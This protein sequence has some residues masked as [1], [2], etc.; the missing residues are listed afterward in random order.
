MRPKELSSDSAT[1]VDVILHTIDWL[2]KQN[3]FYNLVVLLEPTSPLRES[4]DIDR[5]LEIMQENNVRSIVSVSKVESAHPLFLFRLNE[6]SKLDP[7]SGKNP[8]SVRRQDIENLYF[9]EG[10]VYCSEIELLR[11]KKRFLP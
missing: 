2:E 4:K 11:S 6:K 7:Y 10:S 3:R 1:T 9:L 8:N 5:C